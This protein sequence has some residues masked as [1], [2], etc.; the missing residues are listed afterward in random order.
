ME[1]PKLRF[2]I[3]KF[4]AIAAEAYEDGYEAGFHQGIGPAESILYLLRG[5]DKGITAEKR[6]WMGD[7]LR[8]KNEQE[9]RLMKDK[10]TKRA[11]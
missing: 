10:I 3:E 2:Y 1:P 11:T 9:R 4:T 6:R 7:T 5:E 8:D